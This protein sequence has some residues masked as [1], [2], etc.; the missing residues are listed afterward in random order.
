MATLAHEMTI[1]SS[2]L[3]ERVLHPLAWWSWALSLAAVAALVYDPLVHVLEIGVITAVVLS[4]RQRAPWARTYAFAAIT[5]GFVVVMRVAFRV[6]FGGDLGT[7]VLFR[8]PRIGLPFVDPS[9]HLL[10]SVTAD[11]LL[12]GLYDG[13][14]LATIVLAVGA[15]GSLANPRKALR[16]LPSSLHEFT[17]ALVVA[18]AIFPMMVESV[19]RV[20]DARRIRPM[21]STGRRSERLL[22]LVVPVLEDALENALALAAS[23]D[24]RGYGRTGQRDQRR[25]RLSST[26][27]V[28]GLLALMAGT[29]TA[30][31]ARTP[32][33]M[34]WPLL[35]LG[36]ALALVGAAL[37]S[38]DVRRT[39]YRPDTWQLAESTTAFAGLLTLVGVIALRVLDP[40]ALV[41]S[42]SPPTWPGLPLALAGLLLVALVPA[43]ATPR[44]STEVAS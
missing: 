16:S 17:T 7:L 33:W 6:V 35:G 18:V 26:A 4:R 8:L 1:K 36:L 40:A 37:N 41:V 32:W 31:D 29:Y 2:R 13:L 42:S 15:A 27:L 38:R 39:V 22:A 28:L 3:P 30:L 12:G 44:P 25:T 5:A 19:L 9:V 24:A 23:M 11:S 20:R 34:G 43:V 14:R 10:G 21:A